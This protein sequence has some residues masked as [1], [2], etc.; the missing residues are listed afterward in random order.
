M[1]SKFLVNAEAYL[2]AGRLLKNKF[3]TI[4]WTTCEAHCFDLML[5]YNGQI[6][7]MKDVVE[8]VKNIKK[9]ICNHSWVL[10]LMQKFTNED[11]H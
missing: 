7:R 8:A 5:E 10:N 9:H 11:V 4:V 3:P 2:T 1:F 6:E